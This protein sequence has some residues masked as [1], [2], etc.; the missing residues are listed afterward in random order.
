MKVKQLLVISAVTCLLSLTSC[1]SQVIKSPESPKPQIKAL[2]NITVETSP[3]A[4]QK[5]ADDVEFDIDTFLTT[6]RN[7][8]DSRE[9]LAADGDFDLNVV[10]HDVRVRGTASA[11]MLGFFAGDDHLIGDAIILNRSGEVVYTYTAEASYAL[12]GFV[13]GVD[14]TRL[15]WL[16]GKFSEIV[17]DELVVNRDEKE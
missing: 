6:L 15:E 4:V 14:S 3:Q 16:Y 9:L 5:I 17:S 7:A 13:G 2:Q 12:G 11:I 8:L 1:A 10:I